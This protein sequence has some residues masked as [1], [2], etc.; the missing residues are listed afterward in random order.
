M[1]LYGVVGA[2]IVFVAVFSLTRK[3]RIANLDSQG[4]V[5]IC[6]G[7]SLT[8]GYE[9]A[10]E[11]SYPHVLSG[12]LEQPVI[13]AGVNGDTTQTALQRLQRDVL[14]KDPLLVVVILGGN[15]FLRKTSSTQTFENIRV[16]VRTIKQQGAMVA[17]GQIG[18]LLM[19]SYNQEYKKIAA[20]EN[21]ILIPNVLGGVFGNPK[22][23]QDEIHPNTAG[24]VLIAQKINKAIEKYLRLNQKVRRK[25]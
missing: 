20:E 14:E 5:V 18:P 10:P 13:N 1:Y 24:N 2:V 3:E 21:A 25:L 19:H 8:A 12:F 23:M 16:I 17:L 7:D 15:D 22:L 9:T 11:E 4:S 6:F